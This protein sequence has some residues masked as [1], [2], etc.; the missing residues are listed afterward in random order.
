MPSP[1]FWDSFGSYATGDFTKKWTSSGG[2][3]AI[4]PGAGPR[5][6]PAAYPR[7]L[8]KTVTPA[9]TG[10]WGFTVKLIGYALDLFQIFDA[11]NLQL[12]FI[13]NGDGTLS[14][15]TYGGPTLATSAFAF[16]TGIKYH[17]QIKVV[18]NGATGYVLVK[19][20]G[21]N[22]IIDISDVD[23]QQ[24]ANAYFTSFSPT[25]DGYL[26]DF[27]Y[28]DDLLGELR[29]DWC[30]ANGNGNSSQLLGSD[31]DSVDNYQQVDDA[32]PDGDATCVESSTVG[33]KD[34]YPHAGISHNPVTIFGVQTVLCVEK[35]D[36]G[37]RTVCPVVRSGGADYDGAAV[38][39]SAGSYAYFL[40]PKLVDPATSA[41]W[42]KAAVNAAE[43][44]MKV[45]S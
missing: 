13:L 22:T 20:N 26:A 38:A 45:V 10:A 32:A 25:F 1:I 3:T 14:V 43:I 37:E 36:A 27:Y 6:G 12:R 8:A 44:G 16:S 18:I 41:A 42:L 9:A 19:V 33:Q 40:E 39:P 11:G 29:A 24:T 4:V 23:T 28:A 5:G 7:D 30:P 21:T 15:Q 17:V 2:S 34:T 35:D 31:A